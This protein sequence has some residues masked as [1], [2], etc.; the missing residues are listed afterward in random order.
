MG[1]DFPSTFKENSCMKM[2][3]YY[4]R[5]QCH[6]KVKIKH[7]YCYVISLIWRRNWWVHL[8]LFQVGYDMAKEAANRAFANAG[9]I[10]IFFLSKLVNLVSDNF[11]NGQIVVS[12]KVKA[13]FD[14]CYRVEQRC[15][16]GCRTTR[17][18]LLQWAHH[19]RSTG[20]VWRRS[21]VVHRGIFCKGFITYID[22]RRSRVLQ[23]QHV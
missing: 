21:V 13:F 14:S 7:K 18:F 16:A 17:L 12:D 5:R 20:L 10:S 11:R 23:V 3:T 8:L 4:R 9:K 2:V 19:L 15:C 22:H 1:T 6:S